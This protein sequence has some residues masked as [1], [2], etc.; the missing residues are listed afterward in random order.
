[1]EWSRPARAV[2]LTVAI[3]PQAVAGIKDLG[4]GA[5]P[6]RPPSTPFCKR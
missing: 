6:I 4:Y 3:A 2:A 5:I 1:M